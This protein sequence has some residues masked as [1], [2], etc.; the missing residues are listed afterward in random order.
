MEDNDC[1]LRVFT[2]AS[3]AQLTEQFLLH[4]SKFIVVFGFGY[5]DI[6]EIFTLF[7]TI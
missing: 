5:S 6:Y 7:L 4:Y 1:S 3:F 2:V